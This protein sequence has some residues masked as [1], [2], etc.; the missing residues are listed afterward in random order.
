MA[1]MLHAS[2]ECECIVFQ[3]ECIVIETDFLM[4][5]TCFPD[6]CAVQHVGFVSAT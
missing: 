3:I 4:A 1:F 5:V 2:C 6:V